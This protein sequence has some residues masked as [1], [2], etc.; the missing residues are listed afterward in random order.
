MK[1]LLLTCALCAFLVVRPAGAA[2]FTDEQHRTLDGIVGSVLEEFRQD[3]GHMKSLLE[4]VSAA[5]AASGYDKD[6]G[7]RDVLARLRAEAERL[8]NEV[9]K[10]DA[11]ISMHR[12]DDH[13]PAAMLYLLAREQN[14]GFAIYKWVRSVTEIADLANAAARRS[15]PPFARLC[16][17]MIQVGETEQDTLSTAILGLT[18]VLGAAPSHP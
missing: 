1:I 15:D 5:Y 13:N 2:G 3:R 9:V 17:G 10:L 8:D 7:S 12:A 18:G 4:G 6:T 11:T 16:T 14:L